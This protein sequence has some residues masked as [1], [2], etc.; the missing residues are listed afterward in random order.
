MEERDGQRQ[1][2]SEEMARARAR[3]QIS[4]GWN[5]YW[6]NVPEWATWVAIIAAMAI[7]YA[8]FGSPSQY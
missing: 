8:L 7:L 6:A 3:K 5:E 1:P 2:T 4:A